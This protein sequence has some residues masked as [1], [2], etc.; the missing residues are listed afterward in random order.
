MES[1]DV[2]SRACWF[3]LLELLR[4]SW[5]VKMRRLCCDP[6]RETRFE[7]CWMELTVYVTLLVAFLPEM[8]DCSNSDKMA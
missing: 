4:S 1:R 6:L 3:P 8:N 2:L 7:F 5:R